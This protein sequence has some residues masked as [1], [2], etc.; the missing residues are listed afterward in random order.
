MKRERRDVLLWT[1]LL[2]LLAAALLV[3]W[4]IDAYAGD[5][6]LI[7]PPIPRPLPHNAVLEIQGTLP[8]QPWPEAGI[9]RRDVDTYCR[10]THRRVAPPLDWQ[11][12]YDCG[13]SVTGVSGEKVWRARVVVPA[14]E[15]EPGRVVVDWMP[16][17]VW[18]V[19]A[20]P[21]GCPGYLAQEGP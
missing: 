16:E 18:C 6:S 2:I 12:I 21:G 5:R 20:E 17:R 7:F 8:G 11:D 9:A 4:C 15:T 13:F 19:A 3:L 14:T 10:A 1:A